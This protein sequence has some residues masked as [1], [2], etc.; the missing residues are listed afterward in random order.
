MQRDPLLIPDDRGLWCPAGG[1]HIDPWRPVPRAVVTHAHSDHASR[2]SG[3]YLATVA[4]AAM[5]RHRLGAVAVQALGWGE[6][7]RIGDATISLH[8]SGHLPGA[9]QVRVEVAGEIWVAS[10]DYKTESDGLAEPFEPVHCHGFITECTFGLPVYRWAPQAE[11]AAGILDWWRAC[12]DEGGTAAI[13]AY[14]LG[15]AQRLML[16]LAGQGPGPLLVHPTIAATSAVLRDIGYPVP[17]APVLAPGKAPPPGALVLAPPQGMAALADA[18]PG[19]RVAAAS[20]WMALRGT[21]RR[22]GA[23]VGFTLSDHADWPGLNAAVVATGAALVRTT[24][25]YDRAFARWLAGRGLDA[26]PL[27]PSA[28]QGGPE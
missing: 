13:G 28:G 7:L 22:R 12:A 26:Q 2:G 21:R 10:G 14:S 18:A 24:H 17:E 15:K 27:A 1:F 6:R 3:S 8:P 19:L 25:G 9:A 16:L 23:G 4:T 20:G 11:V 5:L